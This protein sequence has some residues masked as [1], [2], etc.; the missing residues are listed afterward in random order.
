MRVAHLGPA[1]TYTEAAAVSYRADAELLA[2][3]TV[4]LAVDAVLAGEA[5]AAVCAIENS[6]EGPVAE[7]MAILQRDPPPLRIAAE[8][9]IA[10]RHALVG[11]PDL[12]LGQVRV[13]YSHPQALAQCREH[14]ATLVPQ[15][16]A[17]P[18]LS[19][20]AAITAAAAEPAA[21]AISNAHAAQL[22]SAKIYDPDVS[23]Q[24]ANHTRFVALAR[25]DSPAS[26]DDK[27]S[28]VFTL[29]EDRP[30]GLLRILRPF[31]AREINITKIE[32]RPTGQ[33][34]GSYTFFIDTQGHRTDPGVEAAISE[35]R[36]NTRWLHVLG[37]YPRWNADDA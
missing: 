18:A 28:L 23:D 31:A 13:V 37:S 9:V 6:L 36:P 34:L 35:S 26:G 5:D 15:A 29:E 7:T 22:Y 19:T 14:L 8:I 12:D 25:D 10:I 24:P 30:G 27:T 3:S 21:L 32:S 1:G 16:R 33:R 4:G 17:M 2:T 11:P 20:A